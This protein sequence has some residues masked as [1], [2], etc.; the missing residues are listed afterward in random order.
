M[1]WHPTFRPGCSVHTVITSCV[2]EYLRSQLTILLGEST[3]ACVHLGTYAKEPRL[4]TGN[5]HLTAW[6]SVFLCVMVVKEGQMLSWLS[7]CGNTKQLGISISTVTIFYGFEMRTAMAEEVALGK[8]ESLKEISTR[9]Y[10]LMP[11][12][13]INK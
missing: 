7:L 5:S 6:A 9:F 13:K 4:L 1:S 12:I 10:S 3:Q 2:N 11:Q 8:A